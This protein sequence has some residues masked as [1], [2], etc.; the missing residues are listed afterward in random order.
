M[1]NVL[2][3]RDYKKNKIIISKGDD[4]TEM[5]FVVRGK[6]SVLKAPED[7][8]ANAIASYSPS[9]KDDKPWCVL[10]LPYASPQRC[11]SG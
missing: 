9:N 2:E 8:E 4:A 6:A 5:Y 3:K 10:L 7:T 11:S 1:A